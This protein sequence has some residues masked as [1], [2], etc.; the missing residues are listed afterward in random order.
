MS[1]FRVVARVEDNSKKDGPVG[2]EDA[3]KED[4]N[5]D[6]D[7]EILLGPAKIAENDPLRSIRQDLIANYSDG[8]K[9]D[10]S[11]KNKLDDGGG[12][13]FAVMAKSELVQH[14]CNRLNLSRNRLHMCDVDALPILLTELNL[15]FNDLRGL[16]DFTK[17]VNLKLLYVNDNPN[18]GVIPKCN[19]KTLLSLN[20]S[21]CGLT[22]IPKDLLEF[23]K[24]EKL[25]LNHNERIVVIP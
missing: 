24:L 1:C 7:E 6:E 15:A 11:K 9:L 12:K 23:L 2:P 4:E 5:E 14:R 19:S 21:N 3:R 10:L 16:L 17:L 13:L 20:C 18:L 22:E 25:W 8:G